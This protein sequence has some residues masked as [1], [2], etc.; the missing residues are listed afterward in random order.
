MK[1]IELIVEYLNL[2]ISVKILAKLFKN[3]TIPSKD[4]QSD[5]LKLAL[6]IYENSLIEII[7]SKI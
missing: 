3:N 7:L 4:F 6:L 5:S 1:Y 2:H